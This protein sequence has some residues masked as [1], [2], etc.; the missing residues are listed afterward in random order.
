MTGVFIT[1]AISTRSIAMLLPVFLSFAFFIF[2]GYKSYKGG[3]LYFP[4]LKKT[5]IAI[6]LPV[7]VVGCIGFKNYYLFDRFIISTGSGAV[8]WLGS[9]SDT[10]GDDPPYRG[11]AYNTQNITED[12]SHLSLK[13]DLLLIEAAKNNIKSNPAGYAWWSVKK[14]GRLLVGSNL[15]WFFPYNNVSAWQA[16]TGSSLLSL[17]CKVFEI[18]LSALIAVYGIVGLFFVCRWKLTH[19]LV[20]SGTVLYLALFSIPFLA[21][22]RFGLPIVVLLTLPA[23]FLLYKSLPSSSKHRKVHWLCLPVVLTIL[24]QIFVFG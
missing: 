4:L 1:L 12:S 20:L 9:R 18:V 2:D 3:R 16:G 11:L 22:Q 14:I 15:A 21:I 10:E 6:L 13:G 5:S 8:L 7:V 24:L 23:A 17:I 19:G